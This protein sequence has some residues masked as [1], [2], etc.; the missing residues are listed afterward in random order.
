MADQQG[1]N[2]T[3]DQ[4]RTSKAA[5]NTTRG[6][7]KMETII[8]DRV[9]DGKAVCERGLGRF[10]SIPLNDLPSGVKEG[11]VLSR[12]SPSQKWAIDSKKEQA[13]HSTIIDKMNSLF[14]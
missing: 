2:K 3:A 10:E 12:M 7:T 13:R 4:Q 8:V 11:S 6:Q 5:D 14:K 1:T 9:E